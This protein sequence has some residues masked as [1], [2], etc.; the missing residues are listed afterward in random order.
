M[1]LEEQ[2]Q[3]LRNLLAAR[4]GEDIFAL[5]GNLGDGPHQ[6]L[7]QP[8][9]QFNLRWRAFGDNPSNNST[10]GL[11][12]KPGKSL[13][14]RITNAIDALLEERAS[15]LTG[16]ALPRS[17]RLAAEDWFG[18]AVTGPDQGL[19]RGMAQQTDRRISVV[20][21][22]SGDDQAP[23]V[24]V[25]DDG[26]GLGPQEL[27]TTILSLQAGNKIRKLYQIGAFGQGGAASLGFADYVIVVSRRVDEPERVAFTVVR[28][29][30]LDASYKEDCYAFLMIGGP[31]GSSEVLCAYHEG[32]LELYQDAVSP[33][34]S[35]FVRGTLVRHVHYRLTGINKS[36]APSPG[37]L[38]HYLHYSVFDP[39]LP[40]RVV[41]L[42]NPAKARNELVTG[43]RNRL[44]RL[45]TEK[46]AVEDD[47]EARVQV[48]HYRPMEY[49]TPAGQTEPCIGV[50]Y[51]VVLAYRKKEG[52]L[53][54]RGN[55]AELFVQPNYPILGTLNGQ[56]QGE[57]ASYL[58]REFGLT[59]LSKHM[60]IHIDASDADS[61]VRRQLFS[62]SREG[63]K[64]GP[65]LDGLVN[66]IRRMIEDD[67]TLYEI[68]QEL[69]DR[70]AKRES[71][72]TREEVRLQVS[73][74]LKEAG[75][76]VSDRANEDLEG[77]GEVR[78]VTRHKPNRPIRPDPL[79]T[80]PFPN[81]TRFEIVY[82]E[83]L[84]Q[85]HVNDSGLVIVETDADQE[86][87]IR[88]L[89]HIRADPP[90]L[91]VETKS[92]LRGG[93]IRWRLRAK[94]DTQIGSF[95]ELIVS[96]TRPD[97]SQLNGSCAFEILPPRE[98]RSKQSIGQV[99]PFEITPISPQDSETWEAVW[100][101]DMGGPDAQ[102]SHAYKVLQIGGKTVVFY[103]TVFHPFAETV[104]KLK[105]KNPGLLDL[106]TV[107]YEIWIAYH[108]ILQFNH[109]TGATSVAADDER[110]EP[111]FDQ[112]RAL[113]ARMQI[114]QAI[115]VAEL[116]RKVM[117]ATA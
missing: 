49:V 82:P 72:E 108:A 38:Y 55:S 1:N 17:P 95:G 30:R 90:V 14:E 110:F 64:E 74:L 26:V 96:L 10:I 100:P 34:V 52:K 28:V 47:P 80:L 41:D 75:F 76:K 53:E 23:T 39:I 106:F 105:A 66:S 73:R 104:E 91:E 117:T 111:Y 56:T 3:L 83:D 88:G 63:F 109:S 45:A 103:S 4:T 68:E 25:L 81:V 20:L 114:K 113:V 18:R 78:P 9:G 116:M 24:D 12:T 27:P 32:P 29:L 59:L 61:Q 98:V 101:N 77:T 21:L 7:D 94:Q 42:R 85:I 11:G 35:P 43:G 115:T 19:F 48:R 70:L 112:E 40:F 22:E 71:A 2:T 57:L 6:G 15:S 92:R 5:L 93:R 62:S 107:Q 8:F 86:Y 36:L 46:A 33:K 69:T 51:W 50:E 65:I 99:P 58:L 44:M 79:P 31:D 60:V 97:G 89:I 16:V 54:L 102:T 87:D 67:Q 13:T 84:L 37:N